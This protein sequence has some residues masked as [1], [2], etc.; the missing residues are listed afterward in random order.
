MNRYDDQAR[1]IFQFAREEAKALGSSQVGPEHLLLGVMRAGGLG[2]DVLTRLGADLASIRQQVHEQRPARQKAASYQDMPSVTPAARRVME[3][4][5]EEAR[6]LGV[7]L[8]STAHILLALLKSDHEMVQHLLALL[9][10]DV[11]A[12]GA[13][14]R[15]APQAV[16]AEPEEEVQAGDSYAL[17][18]LIQE[19]LRRSG[20]P[21]AG[22][23]E[24]ELTTLVLNSG[25]ARLHAPFEELVYRWLTGP[26]L[27][28]HRKRAILRHLISHATPE[29]QEAP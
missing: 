29:R 23:T 8:T 1:A 14:L 3:V 20:T 16:A 5:A 25:N 19:T 9:G 24:E 18:P 21:P 17:E 2:G 15:A 13:E 7:S 12:L 27:P 6:A 26:Q 22:M 28:E 4:A 11:E 10:A